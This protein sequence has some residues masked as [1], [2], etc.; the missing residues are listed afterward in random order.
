MDWQERWMW[1]TVVC[2]VLY[3]GESTAQWQCSGRITFTWLWPFVLC[4]V[5]NGT[6]Q[7]VAG[8]LDTH[9]LA[10]VPGPVEDFDEV[11]Q[12]ASVAGDT[13]Q[14][15]LTDPD[16]AVRPLGDLDV[17][18]FDPGRKASFKMDVRAGTLVQF[19]RAGIKAERPFSFS[20]M[21]GRALDDG[22]GTSITRPL[23][24][25]LTGKLAEVGYIEKTNAGTKLLVDLW[26]AQK[27]WILPYPRPKGW[28]GE[29]PGYF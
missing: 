2:L 17:T 15:K 24:D 14:Y 7:L 10:Q 13:T 22:H 6:T 12:V 18:C 28:R 4:L 8:F 23:W 25:R 21:R 16:M 1:I 26:A 20:C 29:W 9:R 27:A 5:V 19:V 3:V 11:Q